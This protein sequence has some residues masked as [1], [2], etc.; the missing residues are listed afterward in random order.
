MITKID[1]V[2]LKYS[3]I[4]VILFYLAAHAYACFNLFPI[5]DTVNHVFDYK[6]VAEAQ[7][8]RYL[9]IFVQI[10]RGNTTAPWLISMVSIICLVMVTY[11]LTEMLSFEK[12]S[13]IVISGGVLS[14]NL[15]VTAIKVLHIYIEDGLMLSLLMAVLGVYLIWK[16][17]KLFILTS[18][19]CFFISFGLYQAFSSTMAV[20]VFILGLKYIYI[21]GKVTRDKIKRL[22][23]YIIPIV[24]GV[25]FYFAVFEIIK[26][27][28]GVYSDRPN[29]MDS[30]FG[31]DVYT[32][33]DQI[34]DNITELVR[35]F[36][37]P[38]NSHTGGFTW[39]NMLQFGGCILL[40]FGIKNIICNQK[41]VQIDGKALY[42]CLVILIV[43]LI[44][45]AALTV[46]VF[47]W[48]KYLAFR[49]V[50]AIFL[51]YLCFIGIIDEWNAADNAKTNWDKRCMIAAF[52][53]ILFWN[54][55]LS[56]DVYISQ[57]Y[58]YE[59]AKVAVAKIMDDIEDNYDMN[60]PVVLIGNLALNDG[61]EDYTS[62]Y[63]NLFVGFSNTSIGYQSI[64]TTMVDL[65][66]PALN[67]ENDDSIKDE[68]MKNE[69]VISMPIYPQKGYHRVI[70]GR[71]VVKLADRE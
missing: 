24:L 21:G 67:F 14:A 36:F 55:R 22:A 5:W 66:G 37:I 68:Y 26:A 48:I 7:L 51:I 60:T 54:I 38:Y 52:A 53:L 34:Y 23:D 19:L 25:V 61:Y 2:R 42:Y 64:T 29:T 45:T 1:R 10:I 56:N 27:T 35:L 31:S 20:V 47:S 69:D 11:L 30:A 17:S 28:I 39:F 57:Q 63:E 58:S 62:E 18:S 65:L 9:R 3:A 4:G 71:I 46:N 49:L 44:P 15:S 16:K 13:S 50:Y 70:D 41:R 8:G 12:A 32:L 6:G 33:I 43:G 40:I 59:R